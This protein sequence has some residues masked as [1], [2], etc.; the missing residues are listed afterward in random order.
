MHLSLNL[1]SCANGTSESLVD[2]LISRQEHCLLK[3]LLVEV[4]HQKDTSLWS[5]TQKG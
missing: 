1:K 5:Y 2:L 4:I 3:E